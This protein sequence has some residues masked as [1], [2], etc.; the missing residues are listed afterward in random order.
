[1]HIPC[2]MLKMFVGINEIKTSFN[3]Q[4]FSLELEIVSTEGVCNAT[5]VRCGGQELNTPPAY[6]SSPPA[7]SGV[8]VARYLVFC[9]IFCRSLFV[10]FLLAI[11]LSVLL[12]LTASDYTFGICKLFLHFDYY[13]PI[14]F[15][16]IIE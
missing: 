14:L 6:L 12:R 7:F 5:G 16:P 2:K 8:D 15:F 3:V 10:L 4:P 9:V 13:T 11:V 1:M